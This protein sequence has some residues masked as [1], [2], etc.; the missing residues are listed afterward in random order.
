[1]EA[2]RACDRF[3]SNNF[4]STSINSLLKT[5]AFGTP[6]SSPRDASQR[7]SCAARKSLDLVLMD[8]TAGFEQPLQTSQRFSGVRLMRERMINQSKTASS[9]FGIA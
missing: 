9:G 4:P 8:F 3:C 1:M 2:A 5:A 6:R 7:L